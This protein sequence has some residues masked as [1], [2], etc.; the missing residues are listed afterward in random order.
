[1]E[2]RFP[3][4]MVFVNGILDESIWQENLSQEPTVVEK[5]KDALEDDKKK[6]DCI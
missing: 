2:G 5:W 3:G 1:L 6:T 4:K